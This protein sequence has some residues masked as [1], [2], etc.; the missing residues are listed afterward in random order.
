MR[1]ART[2]L[3]CRPTCTGLA[4]GSLLPSGSSTGP[5]P[6]GSASATWSVLAVIST[7]VSGWCWIG[8]P[9]IPG[10][11]AILLD[12]RAIRDRRAFL[13]AARAATRLRPVVAIRAGGLLLDPSGAADLVFGAALRRAGILFV[14]PGGGHAGGYRDADKRHGPCV[15]KSGDCNE[16]D[17]SGP[18]RRRCGLAGRHSSCVFQPRNRTGVEVETAGLP[19]Q[20]PRL[21][22]RRPG[23]TLALAEIVALLGGVPEVG[24][25]LAVHAPVG[26]ADD[27]RSRRLAAA[28][29]GLQVPV[30][31]RLSAKAPVSLIAGSLTEPDCRSSPHRN[32]R[33][34]GSCISS[35]TVAIVPLRQSFR[36]ARCCPWLL[37]RAGGQ[38]HLCTVPRGRSSRT[39]RGGGAVR[40]S[41]YGIPTVPMRA[42]SEPG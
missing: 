35:R 12:I 19:A 27:Q 24:G 40:L 37:I 22:S 28:A 1:R 26:A 7:S 11:R 6:T 13:S 34:A 23:Q 3:W 9:G 39:D 32:R 38:E 4:I 42:A 36:P 2:C 21:G 17:W 33:C 29:P 31:V 20:C 14:R 18:V 8:C 15:G 41:A 5:V 16:R 10:R 25:V 30:L